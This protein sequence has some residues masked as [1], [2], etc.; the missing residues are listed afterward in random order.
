[1][2]NKSAPQENKQAGCA[3]NTRPASLL[4]TTVLGVACCPTADQ[5]VASSSHAY[6][7]S[8]SVNDSAIRPRVFII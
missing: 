7:A 2:H 5:S 3:R 4:G 8:G 6:A 1:M